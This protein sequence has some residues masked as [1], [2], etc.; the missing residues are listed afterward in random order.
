MA[1]VWGVIGVAG[2]EINR[3]VEGVLKGEIINT[4]L[5]HCVG[6]FSVA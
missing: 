2:A 5:T 3:H 6:D 1:L 4:T